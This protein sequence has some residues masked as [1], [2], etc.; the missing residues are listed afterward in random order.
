MSRLQ[1]GQV[2]TAV[3]ACRESGIRV[4]A[5][6][7]GSHLGPGLEGQYGKDNWECIASVSDLPTAM[8]HIIKRLDAFQQGG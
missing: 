8:A 5:I 7:A 2:N 6:G 1:A 3:K 4:Y